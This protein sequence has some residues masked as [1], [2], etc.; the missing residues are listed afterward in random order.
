MKTK[1]IIRILFLIAIIIAIKIYYWDILSL[2]NNNI[3]IAKI[4][5]KKDINL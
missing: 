2:S 5:I 4:E 1:N 3:D